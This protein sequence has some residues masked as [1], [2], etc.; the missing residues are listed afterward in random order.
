MNLLLVLKNKEEYINI[1]N[2]YDTDITYDYEETIDK[3]NNKKYICIIIDELSNI[4]IRKLLNN[5]N[6]K[7]LIKNTIIVD[8]IKLSCYQLLDRE[9]Q[10]FSIINHNMINK[11]L[12]YYIEEIIK[13]D[14]IY[15]EE[16]ASIYKDISNILKRMGISPEKDGFHYLRKAIYECYINP[17]LLDNINNKL[18]PILSKTFHININSIIRSMNYAIEIGYGKSD[19]EYSEIIFSNTID[20]DKGKPTNI[21]FI[22]IIVDELLLLHNITYY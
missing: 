15:N 14:K 5:Y 9:Y 12:I 22:S 11:D 21:S 6:N 1:I 10:V 3:I 2:T 13:K 16:K 17:N 20:I 19:Y 8:D 7:Q 4:N 18:Y